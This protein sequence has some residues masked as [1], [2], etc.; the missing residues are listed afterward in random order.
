[1]INQALDC[2]ANDYMPK[3]VNVKILHVRLRVAER[4]LSHARPTAS[5][6]VRPPTAS[7]PVAKPE[8]NVPDAAPKSATRAPEV[9]PAASLVA[10]SV[11][12]ADAPI[13]IL[14]VA[15]PSAHLRY[16]LR[17]CR[18]VADDLVRRG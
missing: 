4:L 11:E 2:G 10:S 13:A 18:P 6:T 8:G 14:D 9:D 5:G 1:M 3:P 17:Q 16:R 7:L 12:Y 15:G